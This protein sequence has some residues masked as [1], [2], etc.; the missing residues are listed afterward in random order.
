MANV[1]AAPSPLLAAIV[2]ATPTA[3]VTAGTTTPNMAAETA[4]ATENITA[5]MI[6]TL[7]TNHLTPP[8]VL[9][10]QEEADGMLG[11]FK[12]GVLGYSSA[13]A[14]P[15]LC[16]VYLASNDV[17]DAINNIPDQAIMEKL[18]SRYI[19]KGDA[20]PPNAAEVDNSMF[21]Q[22]N[23]STAVPEDIEA[24]HV[25]NNDVHP[26]GNHKTLR[27]SFV[28]PEFRQDQPIES[29][30]DL[31]S[32]PTSTINQEKEPILAA[33]AQDEGD[34][35]DPPMETWDDVQSAANAIINLKQRPSL[36]DTVHPLFPDSTT[37]NR[38]GFPSHVARRR[39]KIWREE[40]ISANFKDAFDQPKLLEDYIDDNT[41][42]PFRCLDQWY[43][44]D[45]VDAPTA[46]NSKYESIWIP[47]CPL[48]T[49]NFK[50]DQR[51]ILRGW[52][53][54][55]PSLHPQPPPIF[56]Q[57]TKLHSWS[58]DRTL[59]SRGYWVQS[60]SCFYRL[61]DPS[62]RQVKLKVTLKEAP[63]ADSMDESDVFS[64]ETLPSPPSQEDL[65]WLQR[66]R[67]GLISN[68]VDVFSL[69]EEDA[70]QYS[71]MTPKELHDKLKPQ[72][73]GDDEPF[74][75][76]LLKSEAE[77]ARV[78][79]SGAIGTNH[80]CKF[81]TC[82][83]ELTSSKVWATGDYQESVLRAERR[84]YTSCSS[85]TSSNNIIR[86]QE[87]LQDKLSFQPCNYLL[88]NGIDDDGDNDDE[89]EFLI[90]LQGDFVS[91]N[92]VD[93][94]DTDMEDD[95]DSSNER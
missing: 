29:I 14:Q 58:V 51:Y 63:D 75:F 68:I 9:I 2:T 42:L 18:P 46:P 48:P 40:L 69:E 95:N 33:A 36:A 39:I 28:R 72:T 59:H 22:D 52:L 82:L 67:L 38:Q 17:S 65:H 56:V 73:L 85:I 5:T 16:D 55:N 71:K 11:S 86:L 37:T 76:E 90:I 70:N 43:L 84:S 25:I 27:A 20:F 83:S 50:G 49:L 79:L 7:T 21:Q 35:F 74:D 8:V 15:D 53:R 54:P 31:E 6:A 66:A 81:L 44:F 64:M 91:T 87:A 60:R 24:D 45:R 3:N 62:S 26:D 94:N 92:F 10:R 32:A 12:S 19:N 23:I 61:Q 77:F 41:E 89:G 78:H 30:V 93:Q 34:P 57:V 47:R 1:T 80:L 88:Q 4:T 13:F